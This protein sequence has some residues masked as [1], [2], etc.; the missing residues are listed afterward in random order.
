MAKIK[1]RVVDAY[2]YKNTGER[3][4]F[5]L[6]K[7]AKTKLYEHLWQGVAGKIEPGE[8]A[9]K[10]AIRELKEE[11]GFSPK[12]IFVADHVSQFYEVHGDRVNLI[13]VFGIEVKEGEVQLSEEHSEYE[14]LPFEKAQERLVWRGQ[15]QGIAVVHE[16]ITKKD[17]RMRWSEIKL[18]EI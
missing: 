14:W 5:L 12:R 17:D 11:T 10:T 8:K 15:K 16:M 3:Y 4:K 18:E 7:R 1:V 9:W 6:L 13:P 2:V